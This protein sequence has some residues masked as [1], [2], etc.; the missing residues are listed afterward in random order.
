[1]APSGEDSFRETKWFYERARGQFADER[2]RRSPSARKQFDSMFPRS[3]FLTK[4]D[5]AKFEN[6]YRCRPHIVSLGSQKNF[7]ELAKV[8]G[9]EWGRGDAGFDEVWFKRLIAKAII[10]RNIERL[11]PYQTWYAGGYRANIV[12][13]ALAK[14]VH[15]A[16][17][18]KRVLDLDQVWRMQRVPIVLER[19]CMAAA[20]A[21]NEV[22]TQPPAG[23]RNLSEWAKKQ[24]CW[25]ELAKRSVAYEG[26]F[27]DWLIDPDEARASKRDER[28][29]RNAKSGVEAQTEVVNQ[30]A[31]YWTKLLAFG[32]SIHKLSPKEASILQA[33]THLPAKIPSDKQCQAA[34]LI[35]DKLEQ[36]Y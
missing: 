16:E 32:N 11:V 8:I 24:A 15:D 31:E 9:E 10:F 35:A 28:R 25:A 3:Q 13:Y 22:I 6:S 20:E 12:T 2:G 5:L 7:A 21:A 14:V 26:D 29:E 18:W 4:T 27:R 23:V 1:L 34:L 17:Q 33:C 36:F 19:A 30:G